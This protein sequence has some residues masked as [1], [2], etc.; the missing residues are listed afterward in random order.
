MLNGSNLKDANL[1]NSRFNGAVLS[2]VDFSGSNLGL[3]RFHGAVLFGTVLRGATLAE[4]RFAGAQIRGADFRE[5]EYLDGSPLSEAIRSDSRRY[6]ADRDL[7]LPDCWP[8][9]S[10]RAELA[11]AF[12]YEKWNSPM[13]DKR[14]YDEVRGEFICKQ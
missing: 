1:Y 10:L 9:G 4:T 11:V 3:S 8:A 7:G 6:F 5:A 12:E 14:E 13:V 2:G